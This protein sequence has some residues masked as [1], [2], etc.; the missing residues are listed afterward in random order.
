VIEAT[1]PCEE[2]VALLVAYM[3]ENDIEFEQAP[4]EA[5]SQL[6]QLERKGL[7]DALY[8]EDGDAIILGAKCGYVQINFHPDATKQS[9]VRYDAVPT[10]PRRE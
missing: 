5:E 10:N 6:I 3:T 2:I 8:I 4:Y 9:C 7:V 1:G